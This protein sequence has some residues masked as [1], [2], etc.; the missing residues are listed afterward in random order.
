M[1]ASYLRLLES[2]E[3][4]GPFELG[5]PYVRP[6]QH[7]LWEMRMRGRDGIARGIYVTQKGRRIV[8]LH[9][10]VKKT[11]KTPRKALETARKRLK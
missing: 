6:L 1:Q 8:I 5:M 9:V 4:F 3:E 11:Q 7:A 10:F 2:P